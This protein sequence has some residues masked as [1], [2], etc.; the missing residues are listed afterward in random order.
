[1][2]ARGMTPMQAIESATR[3]AARFM[4][5]S[6]EVGTIEADKMGDLIAVRGDP[7]ADV[8]LLQNVEVVVKGGMALKLPE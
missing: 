6:G 4:G 1:M 7:L 2:V 3:V 8:K 5:W